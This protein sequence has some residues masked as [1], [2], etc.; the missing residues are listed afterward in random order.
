WFISQLSKRVTEISPSILSSNTEENLKR[1]C[2]VINIF[3]MVESGESKKVG[4]FSK[5]DFNGRL[6]IIKEFSIEE[7]KESEVPT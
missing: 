3:N 4:I 5:E 6:L 7:T 2:K 1:E